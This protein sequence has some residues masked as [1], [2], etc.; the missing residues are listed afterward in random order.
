MQSGYILGLFVG[1]LTRGAI[2]A[3]LALGYTMVYGII[4][5]INFAHGEIYMIGAF[6]ALILS[7][8]FS[9]AGFPFLAI[10]S[11]SGIVVN[12]SIVLLSFLK[13]DV[14]AGTAL[15]EA[16]EGAAKARFRAVILTSLTTIAGLLPLMF[17]TSSLAA[18]IRPIAV[19]ICFGLSFATLLIL[20]VVPA[21]ILL[22]ERL[23]QHAL[24]LLPNRTAEALPGASIQGQQS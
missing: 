21:F 11:L 8:V 17:E 1:G 5:L 20:L 2:Y 6:T 9:L 22:L 18:M 14:E 3:L 19:T 15:R 7:S 23:K 4:K 16:L 10:L 13:R 12:D 24:R